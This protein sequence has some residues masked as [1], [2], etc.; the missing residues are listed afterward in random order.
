MAKK[1][2]TAQEAKE[3][4]EVRKAPETEEEK[5]KAPEKREAKRE[6]EPKCPSC[7]TDLKLV[8]SYCSEDGRWRELWECRTCGYTYNKK[9]C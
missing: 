9:S 6:P 1:K 7:R 8:T 2:E 4:R 3:A 5:A